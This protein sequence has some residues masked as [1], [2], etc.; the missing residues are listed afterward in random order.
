MYCVDSCW[1]RVLKHI[2]LI[3]VLGIISSCGGTKKNRNSSSAKDHRYVAKKLSIKDRAPLDLVRQQ[4]AKLIDI[5]IPFSVQPLPGFGQS[6]TES[7]VLG[8]HT[9]LSTQAIIDFYHT[10][11]ER[12]GWQQG[13]RFSGFE[14]LLQFEKPNRVCSISIRPKKNNS[15]MVIFI[16]SKDQ[17]A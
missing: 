12:S 3:I 17:I 16:T 14:T 11:M 8:Y 6:S 13:T 10:E 5:P 7:V 4:E 9:D 1:R 2:S 15:D